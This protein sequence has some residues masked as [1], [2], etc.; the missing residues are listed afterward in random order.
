MADETINDTVFPAWSELLVTVFQPAGPNFEQRL[1][2][3][4]AC[5]DDNHIQ[6]HRFV[7][8]CWGWTMQSGLHYKMHQHYLERRIQI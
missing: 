4:L 3:R 5:S 6:V 7:W 8:G 1:S 2:L